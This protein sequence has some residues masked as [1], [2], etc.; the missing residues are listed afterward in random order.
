MAL[1]WIKEVTNRDGQI[2]LIQNIEVRNKYTGELV[3]IPFDNFVE[4]YDE[5]IDPKDL[6]IQRLNKIIEELKSGKTSGKVGG[7][8]KRLLPAEWRE[9]E[10]L[11]RQGLK[12]VEIAK[13]YG[14]SD[15]TVST[16]RSQMRKKGEEV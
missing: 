12:N 14:I 2:C 7:T 11:I 4:A 15:S 16:R 5:Y 6:E 10:E 1:E 8:K 13:E 3:A 9:V